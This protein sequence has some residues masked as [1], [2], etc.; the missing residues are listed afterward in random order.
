[1]AYMHDNVD[2]QYIV[3][4]DLASRVHVLQK[5]SVVNDM[6]CIITYM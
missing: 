6:K 3:Y 2:L 1:M 5:S 4:I